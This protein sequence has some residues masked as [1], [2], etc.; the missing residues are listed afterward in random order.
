MSKRLQVIALLS[1]LAALVAV[2][3]AH[4]A[5][6]ARLA[7]APAAASAAGAGAGPGT[8]PQAFTC[9]PTD[10]SICLYGG[11]FEL[12]ARFSAPDGEAGSAHLV[13]LTDDSGYMWFFPSG[14]VEVVAKVLNGC[15][16]NGKYWFFAGGLTNVDVVITVTDSQTGDITQY[17][18][19]QG[20]AF[21]PIQDTSALPV[22]P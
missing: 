8:A 18:N 12:T 22:C 19:L 6:A 5:A 11:R 10:L 3:P 20:T 7:A 1:A 17:H 2:P 21:E 16:I 14:N 4:A 15:G 13:K 9:V